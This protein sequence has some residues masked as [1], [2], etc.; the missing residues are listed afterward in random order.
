MYRLFFNVP[1]KFIKIMIKVMPILGGEFE[2]CR[3]CKGVEISEGGSV[4]KAAKGRYPEQKLNGVGTIDSKP[5][6]DQLH[7]LV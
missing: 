2:N 1:H 3:L 7:H 4:T 6:T 5:S